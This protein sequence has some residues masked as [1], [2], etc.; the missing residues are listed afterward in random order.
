[1][2]S[3]DGFHHNPSSSPRSCPVANDKDF[4]A[5][6]APAAASVVAK[7]QPI[8]RATAGL[9]LIAIRVPGVILFPSSLL[10]EPKALR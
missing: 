1:M 6:N 3:I 5:R 7:P 2:K 9:D 4:T 10:H 8:Y